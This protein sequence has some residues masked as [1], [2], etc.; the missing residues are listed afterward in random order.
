MSETN[1]FSLEV[2][3]LGGA[4]A[5]AGRSMPPAAAE[6]AGGEFLPVE[7]RLTAV[8]HRPHEEGRALLARFAEEARRLL[9]DRVG[10][11]DRRAEE[12]ARRWSRRLGRSSAALPADV[13]QTLA[14]YA[15]PNVWR[16][17]GY[18]LAYLARAQAQAARRR[19]EG[20]Y[21][22]DDFGLDMAFLNA[23]LPLG[24]YLYRYYWRVETTGLEHVPKEGPA[25]LV[26]NHSG[27]LPFDGAMIAVATLTEMQPPRL[28]R[29]LVADWFPTLPFLSILLQRT[30]QV[31]A[32]P[33]NALRLLRQGE[34]VVVFPEGYKG[35]GKLY[36]DRYQLARFGRGGFI[37]IAVAA[38]VPIVPVAVVGAEEI[39]PMIGRSHLLARLFGFPYFP[40]TPTFPWLGPLGVIPL[41]TKWSIDF[42]APIHI[43]QAGQRAAANPVV[44]NRLAEQ[45]RS[46]IQQMLLDRLARRRSVFLG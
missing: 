28:A 30:G 16:G 14:Q 11:D 41:P 31:Q 1:G 22:L 26:S 23:V 18:V 7:D 42:G 27:V 46:A 17:M 21:E 45:V 38:G 36:R 34:L 3:D 10:L 35:V 12:L 43:E 39:Y 44:V 29:T 4:S 32:S 24:K 25:L 9:S 33:L 15:D 40:I 6:P 20:R 5:P 37:R 19:A 2:V 8:R 13:R